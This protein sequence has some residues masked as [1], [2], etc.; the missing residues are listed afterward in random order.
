[1]ERKFAEFVESDKSPKHWGQFKDPL[2]YMHLPSTVVAS[3]SLAKEIAGSNTAILF[4][5]IFLSLN[6]LNSVTL[7]FLYMKSNLGDLSLLQ[8]T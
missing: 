7:P 3:L 4:I 1:M 2:C 8:F 5:L 6:P